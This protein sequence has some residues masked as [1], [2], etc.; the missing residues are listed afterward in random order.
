MSSKLTLT[1][2]LQLHIPSLNEWPYKVKHCMI[3]QMKL[4]IWK[5]PQRTATAFITPDQE[6]KRSVHKHSRADFQ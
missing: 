3:F 6:G 2:E 5:L 1:S 4:C